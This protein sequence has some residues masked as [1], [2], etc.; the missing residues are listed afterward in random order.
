M[1]FKVILKKAMKLKSLLKSHKE[2]VLTEESK[3]KSNFTASLEED[4]IYVKDLAGNYV[5]ID[6]E[7]VQFENIEDTAQF[8]FQLELRLADLQEGL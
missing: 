3:K 4:G 8:I 5:S 7:T 1:R 2:I 6:G